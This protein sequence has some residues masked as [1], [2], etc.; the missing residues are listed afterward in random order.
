MPPPGPRHGPGWS[1]RGRSGGSRE[2]R[3][4]PHPAPRPRPA[5]PSGPSRAPP[6]RAEG[7]PAFCGQ[8][9]TAGADDG[10]LGGGRGTGPPYEGARAPAAHDRPALPCVHVRRDRRRGRGPRLPV[11]TGCTRRAAQRVHR[12]SAGAGA[13][14]VHLHDGPPP[15]RGGG[16]AAPGAAA[17]TAAAGGLGRGRAGGRVRAG[18]RRGAVRARGRPPGAR[19]ADRSR[20]VGGPAA[21]AAAPTGP[22]RQLG[23]GAGAAAHVC[24]APVAPR[25]TPD[26]DLGAPDAWSSARSSAAEAAPVPAASGASAEADS[27]EDDAAADDRADSAEGGR[28]D[29]AGRLPRG[30]PGSGGA[31]RCSTSTRTVNGPGR[32]RVVA[33]RRRPCHA[34]GADQGR[35][36]FPG[37]RMR[38][39]EFHSLQGPVAQSGSAP[40]SHRGGQGFKSPQ[41][42]RN[43]SL[44]LRAVERS[45]PI[46]R[47]GGIF[48]VPRNRR[49]RRSGRA[50]HGSGGVRG[51]GGPAPRRVTEASRSTC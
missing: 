33:V 20:G 11:G 23:A 24:D 45:R 8:G 2:P 7:C 31:L 46:G 4:P 43:N 29:A 50:V 41:V 47:S 14:A 21:R 39:L 40:R 9:R 38:M 28:S 35:N 17:Q 22:R 1:R 49:T 44:R 51:P 5:P 13:Q 3:V 19:R 48:V 25:A 36:G 6:P 10:V 37:R 27:A 16:A 42:H 30:G 18:E 12:V 26:V 32:Q 15:G 34:P